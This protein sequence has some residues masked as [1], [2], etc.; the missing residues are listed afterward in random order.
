[1][2]KLYTN[3]KNFRNV[4]IPYEFSTM[5]DLCLNNGHPYDG[6]VDFM[7]LTRSREERDMLLLDKLMHAET[8]IR[9]RIRSE[10]Y[11]LKLSLC[12][13]TDLI[14]HRLYYTIVLE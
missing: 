6:Y 9:C 2:K 1:M 12:C 3:T 10:H 5:A 8:L 14:Y 7:I 13:T 11:S 4:P